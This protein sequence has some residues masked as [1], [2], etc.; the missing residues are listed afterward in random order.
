MSWYVLQL[1]PSQGDRA[2]ENLGNQGIRCYYPKIYVEKLRGGKLTRQL[3]A[4]FPSYL[5][6]LLAREDPAWGKLRSTRGVSRVVSFA[7][8]PAPV[9]EDI[10]QQ[11]EVSLHIMAK[12]GGIRTGKAVHLEEG[13]F[14]GL[15]AV[16]SAYD[17]EDRAIVLISFM[18]K[19]QA[20]KVPV[21]SI[22]QSL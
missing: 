15:T 9:H 20:V 10:I 4:L 19:L 6:I 3:E 1:K 13:A 14:K 12:Q 5:F 16:F 7:G 21:S 22:R 2:A 8:T 17:G 18:Q 11:I